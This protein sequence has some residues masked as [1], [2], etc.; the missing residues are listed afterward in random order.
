MRNRKEIDTRKVHPLEIS[1]HSITNISHSEVLENSTTFSCRFCNE[2][3][4][5][6]REE[7]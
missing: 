4:E 5:N 2:T 1:N 6:V 7:F 3:L